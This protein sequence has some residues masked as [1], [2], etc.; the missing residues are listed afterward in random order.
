[1]QHMHVHYTPIQHLDSSKLL[2]ALSSSL[3]TGLG[4]NKIIVGYFTSGSNS[5]HGAAAHMDHILQAQ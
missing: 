5:G 3:V 1:M 4:I 2:Y